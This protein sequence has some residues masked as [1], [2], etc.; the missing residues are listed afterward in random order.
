MKKYFLSKLANN[1]KN[2]TQLHN[3]YKSEKVELSS[4]EA[5]PKE[6]VV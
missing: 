3:S 1:N 6:N 4:N 2:I 5:I